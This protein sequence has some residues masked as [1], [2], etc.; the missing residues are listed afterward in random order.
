MSDQHKQL[1]TLEEAN[2]RLPL[3]KSIVRDIVSLFHD[4]EQR[5]ERLQEIR[6]LRPERQGKDDLYSEEVDQVERELNE[7]R[8]RLRSF[9]DE[10]L[11]LGVELKDPAQG[12]VDFRAE[13]EGREVYLCWKNGEDD[14]AFWH[15]LNEGFSGRQPLLASVSASDED[16]TLSI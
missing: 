3:V 8:I 2:Q 15:E 14:I 9:V 16:D 11:G 13:F 7:D 4:T 1:F 10:L 5:E 6:S 12:L